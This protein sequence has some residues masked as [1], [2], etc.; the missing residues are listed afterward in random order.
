MRYL[1]VLSYFAIQS[2]IRVFSGPLTK[3][4]E[5]LS[6]IYIILVTSFQGGVF[7]LGI[8]YLRHRTNKFGRTRPREQ[9]DLA[10]QGH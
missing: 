9:V 10:G 3:S 8:D 2:G 6:E 1:N 5:R 4:M 7:G